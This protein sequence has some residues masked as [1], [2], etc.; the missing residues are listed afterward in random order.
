[1]ANNI[2]SRAL[3]G[4]KVWDSTQTSSMYPHGIPVGDFWIEKVSWQACPFG[5][6]PA[7]SSWDIFM[8]NQYGNGDKVWC[9]S[10]KS[11]GDAIHHWTRL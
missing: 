5:D 7:G 3:R 10:H 9:S 4:K 2:L 1:M 11:L 8:S 6:Y